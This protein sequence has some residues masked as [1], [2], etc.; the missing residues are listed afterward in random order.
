MREVAKSELRRLLANKKSVKCTDVQIGDTA[1]CYTAA[2]RESTPRWRGPARI[3]DIDEILGK[4]FG[5]ASA[6]EIPITNIQSGAILRKE[7]S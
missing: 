2:N 3:L 1:L 4:D 7:E 5:P 6:S